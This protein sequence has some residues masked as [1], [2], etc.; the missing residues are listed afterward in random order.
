MLV[1][2]GIIILAITMAIPTI[3]YMTG[4]RSAQSAE[5]AVAAM[6]ARARADAIGSQQPQGVVF[7]IDQTNDRVVMREVLQTIQPNDPAGVTFLDLVPDRDPLPLPPGIRA[8]TIKDNLTPPLSGTIDPFQSYRYLGFNNNT[9]TLTYTGSTT[10]DL[11]I[12]GGV[13]L[14]DGYG[15]L[16]TA[17]YGFRFSIGPVLTGLGNAIVTA[18]ASNSPPPGMPVL[19]PTAS[20]SM[21]YLRAQ[22][23]LVL[24]DRETFQNQERQLSPAPT[25]FDGNP[26]TS[27]G[28]S[29]TREPVI[30]GWLD[31]NTTPL[32]VDRYNGTLIR[33]E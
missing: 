33:A 18:G 6:L 19:W 30:D 31:V 4:S 28:S 13:I 7:L 2:M 5:N 24:V 22:I 29:D 20:S 8:L 15:N 21:P 14:F 23:G 11:G 16:S 26:V 17:Q 3:R 25:T 1:V 12:I 27:S 10:T 9:T 32:L